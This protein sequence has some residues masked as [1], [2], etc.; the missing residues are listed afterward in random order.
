MKKILLFIIIAVHI[1]AQNAVVPILYSHGIADTFKQAFMYARSYTYD[2]HTYEN[3]RYLFPGP[4]AT[5]NYPDATESPLRVNRYETSFGQKNEIDRLYKVYKKFSKRCLKEYKSSDIILFGMSRGASNVLIFAGLYNLSNI[6]AIIAESPYD[7]MSDV[8]ENAM[9][10]NNVSWMPLSYGES[11]AEFIFKKYIRTGMS[12][13]RIAAAI[14]KNIPILISCSLE[15]T[16][17]P[18]STSLKIYKRLRASGHD[19]AHIFILE[20]GRHSKLL[21]GPDGDKYQEVVHAFYKAYG[22][23]N[24]PD[25]ARRGKKQFTQTQPNIE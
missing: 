1:H 9:I 7:S 23:P 16:L 8:I 25:L 17:V 21:S 5:F 2:N 18:Y 4:F 3:K 13:A 15:D 19:K 10:K 6:K 22:L 14:D 11:I 24:D 12:P 20:H